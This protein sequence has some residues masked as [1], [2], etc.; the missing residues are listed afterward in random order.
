MLSGGISGE[1]VGPAPIPTHS[2][3]GSARQKGPECGK[4][5]PICDKA[6]ITRPS[7]NSRRVVAPWEN[8]KHLLSM[9]LLVT[10]LLT[11]LGSCGTEPEY[12]PFDGPAPTGSGFTLS[13]G[14]ATA[15]LREH[16]QSG[17]L[18][19]RVDVDPPG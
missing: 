5:G 10:V 14:V 16:R 1:G 15:V 9:R 2:T 3:L 11:L 19:Q 12:P 8:Q 6:K 7:G 18:R 13:N 4:G 17:E